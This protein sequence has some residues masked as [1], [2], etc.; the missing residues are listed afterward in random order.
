MSEETL[1]WGWVDPHDLIV[2]DDC[3]KEFHY[4][5]AEKFRG[6]TICPECMEEIEADMIR[7]ESK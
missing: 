5:Y 6:N 3:E 1:V 4:R 7:D 2:C